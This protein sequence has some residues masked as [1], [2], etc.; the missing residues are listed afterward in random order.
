MNTNK[1]YFIVKENLQKSSITGEY[2]RDQVTPDVLQDVC[3]KITGEKDFE[4]LYVGNDFTNN[5]LSA[6]YNKGRLAIL[7]YKDVVNFITFSEENINGR[8]SSVQSVATAF[9]IY[10]NCNSLTKNLFYYF[11]VKNG[12]IE[13]SYHKFIYRLMK[14]VGFN[15]LNSQEYLTDTIEPFTSIPDLMLMR[16]TNSGRNQSNN[17]TYLTKSSSQNIDLY[18]KTYGASKYE[19]SLLCYAISELAKIKNQTVTL[20]EVT[21]GNLRILP[22]SSRDVIQKMGNIQ[23][24]QSDFA[25][26]RNSFDQNDSLRSPRYIYNL[27]DRLGKKKCAFCGCEIPEIIHGAHILP[28]AYIKKY[29]NLSLE[30]KLQMAT[31]G[32]NG[33]WL[34]ENHH[35]LFD[36]HIIDIAYDGKILISEYLSNSNKMF[37]QK[38]TTKNNIDKNIMTEQFT[39]YLAKRKEVVNF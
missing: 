32:N 4:Y 2:F 19:T 27:L 30:Q 20:Y 33:L 23:I 1:P 26:E 29:S 6:T 36:E 38:I 18:G 39:Q 7:Y 12:N 24:V 35:K 11:L 16:R 3:F 28:V 8:N 21:E 22:K 31:D 17:P 37:V 10:F 13:T 14:T 25:L 34:C 9:N 5:E 15:F